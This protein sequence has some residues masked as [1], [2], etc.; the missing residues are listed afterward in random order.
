MAKVSIATIRSLVNY[1]NS[2]SHLKKQ[3]IDR[4]LLLAEINLSEL[5]INQTEHLIN[6][7]YYEKLFSFAQQKL[8][9][10][11]IG[12]EFGQ[13][14]SA[15]RWGI[16]GYIAFT[17]PTLK[18]AL[19]K[20]RK[21]QSLAG[22]IGTPFFEKNQNNLILKWIP[23]YQCSYH[24]VEEIITGWSALATKLSLNK[25]QIDSIYFSHSYKGNIA[26]KQI[27]QKYFGC[28]VFFEQDFNGIKINQSALN[29]ALSS[30]DQQVNSALCQQADKIINNL[31]EE[32]PI[33]SVT[34][35]IIHQLPLG[36]PELEQAA[37]QL[38]ISVRT[39]QRKLSDHH[40]TFS[41]MVDNIRQE[42]A[43]SYLKNTN[44]KI[45]YIAQMI[46]FSEQSAFHRAFKRWTKQ[47]PKQFREQSIKKM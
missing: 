44:T 5:Q 35:F 28:K 34:Q 24:I 15:D 4:A 37:K 12:F 30:F 47:T 13:N 6:S 32:S 29:I 41:A 17:S 3:K 36:V 31:I 19:E 22:S 7:S 8:L 38:Q 2:S 43:I 27:Y 21:Y 39:L 42:L 9:N 25:I 18:V 45:I 14:I 46:G 23:A 10:S 40:Q 16:L 33:E 26:D 11:H 20:Q 1:L